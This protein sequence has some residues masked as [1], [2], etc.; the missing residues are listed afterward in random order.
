[1]KGDILSFNYIGGDFTHM[2]TNTTVKFDQSHSSNS[3][4]PLRFSITPDGTHGGGVEY[5]TGVTHVG[6]PGQAGA[7]TQIV[8][9][10]T[11]QYLFS[12]C[13]N[14]SGMGNFSSI[15][16]NNIVENPDVCF[17]KSYNMT[18]PSNFIKSHSNTY[19]KIISGDLSGV[20]SLPFLVNY[21]NN[22]VSKIDSLTLEN[23]KNSSSSIVSNTHYKANDIM[24]LIVE[25]K[26]NPNTSAFKNLNEEKLCTQ[27]M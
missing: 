9:G 20:T 12:Y 13:G 15:V 21:N 3:T 22:A 6:T 8:T 2:Y 10:N 14:H 16:S 11:P 25:G 18:L 4:H 27:I 17:S 19:L 24:T 5:T 1:M 7:Y 23:Y 26:F